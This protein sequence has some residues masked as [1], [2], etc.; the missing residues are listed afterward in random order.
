MTE[1]EDLAISIEMVMKLIQRSLQKPFVT[2]K[3]EIALINWYYIIQFVCLGEM[4]RVNDLSFDYIICLQLSS[5]LT[6]N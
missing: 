1:G 2:T 5:S 6:Q 3:Q 4:V